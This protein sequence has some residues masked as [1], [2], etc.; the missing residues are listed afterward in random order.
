M[1]WWNGFGCGEE[2]RTAPRIAR[3]AGLF[4]ENFHAPLDGT[5]DLWRDDLS[6]E[7]VMDCYLR[8]VADCAEFEVPT[9]VIHLPEENNPCTA[10]GLDRIKKIAEEAERFSVNV[11]FENIWNLTN[12][13]YVLDQIHSPRVGLCYDACH[14]ANRAPNEPLLEKY[15]ARLMALHLHDNGG[16]RKQHC[17]PFDGKI[18]WPA[19]MKAI[20]ETGY[21][22][23]VALEVMNWDYESLTAEEFLH[24]LFE[25]AQRLLK[26]CGIYATLCL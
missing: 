13:T 5:N 8:C 3:D 25:R 2:Y 22:G 16:S 21:T 26:T 14:H 7:A 9:V 12:L 6:G 23:A 19:T 20:A 1:L 24:T 18:D 15:G 4:V 10:F 11:A 17:M